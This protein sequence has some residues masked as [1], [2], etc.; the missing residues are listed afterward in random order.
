MSDDNEKV[1]G[2]WYWYNRLVVSMMVFFSFL[3]VVGVFET[4]RTLFSYSVMA[5]LFLFG[6]HSGYKHMEQQKLKRGDLNE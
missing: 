5:V 3:V 2:E 1:F 6:V 4:F